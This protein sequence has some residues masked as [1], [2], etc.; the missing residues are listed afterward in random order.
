[1]DV[2]KYEGVN[3][4]YSE[5]KC[6][7]EEQVSEI[8]TIKIR[9]EE[10]HRKNS[11]LER[12]VQ[13]MTK[14]FNEKTL[15]ME[16]QVRMS[17]EQYRKLEAEMKVNQKKVQE[18]IKL[19][20]DL[21][22]KI[23]AMRDRAEEKDKTILEIENVIRQK[24][25]EVERITSENQ[26]LIKK[27]DRASQINTQLNAQ[28]QHIQSSLI[29]ESEGKLAVE[30]ITM[31]L[32]NE[33]EQLKEDV[34]RE[35]NA[36]LSAVR[37]EQGRIEE[38]EK[39]MLETFAVQEKKILFLQQDIANLNEQLNSKQLE[40]ADIQNMNTVLQTEANQLRVLSQQNQE[41]AQRYRLE[42]NKIVDIYHKK[43]GKSY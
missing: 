43:F 14:K 13:D 22:G 19:K 36:K 17:N 8:S 33:L 20:G 25:N 42:R 15:E 29:N 32:L 26:S 12:H 5:L 40:C 10:L 23:Q 34:K 35:K 31:D 37:G 1:M 16:Q 3:F 30:K 39:Q 2:S 7:C 21:H 11:E 18:V 28:L 9:W 6:V 24:N 38:H 4:S 27:I 41:K